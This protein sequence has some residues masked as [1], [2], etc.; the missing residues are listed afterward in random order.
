MSVELKAIS[1]NVWYKIK[2]RDDWRRILGRGFMGLDPGT[3]CFSF[4][5]RKGKE[6]KKRRVKKE[7]TRQKRDL[8]STGSNVCPEWYYC[9]K[10]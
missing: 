4:L 7:K 1:V 8:V 9:M 6:R 10:F 3:N 5:R 2:R